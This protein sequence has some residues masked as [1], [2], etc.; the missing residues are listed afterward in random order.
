MSRLDLAAI[1][2]RLM[3]PRGES[4]DAAS[5]NETAPAAVASILRDGVEGPELLFIKRAERVGD[6]WSGDLAF[7]GGKREP[8][9]LALLETAVRETREE[10]GLRLLPA[11]LATR[12]DDVPARRTSFRV[13]QFVFVLDEPQVAVAASAEVA[14]TI[15]MPID[16]LAR[17]EGAGTYLFT[18]EGVSF[19]LP[20]LRFGGYVL[21]GMT[22]RMVMQMLEAMALL[23]NASEG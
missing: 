16:R 3:Q 8:T 18:R 10:V 20:C 6:P 5:T 1:R 13:S 9:D 7:P 14:A 12:L 23:P 21:W 17:N 22:Y 19:E 4:P 15:W 11:M 2:L